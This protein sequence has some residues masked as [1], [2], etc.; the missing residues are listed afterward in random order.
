MSGK[1]SDKGQRTLHSWGGN[2]IKKMPDLLVRQRKKK[3]PRNLNHT[4]GEKKEG[5]LFRRVRQRRK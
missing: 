2:R 4:G 5:K 3:I 1:K